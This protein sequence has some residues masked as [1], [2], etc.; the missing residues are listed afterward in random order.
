M[1]CSLQDDHLFA[2]L[3]VREMIHFSAQLRLPSTMTK[4]EKLQRGEDVIR[5]VCKRLFHILSVS[6]FMCDVFVT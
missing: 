5:E 4:A 6:C 2:N 1:R 3:T